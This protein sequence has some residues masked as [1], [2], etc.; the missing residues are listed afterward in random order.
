[1][2]SGYYSY[3]GG[4][5]AELPGIERFEGQV[6]HPQRWPDD[7]DYRGKRVVVIGSGATAMTLVPAMAPDVEHITMLQ[8]SPTYVVA[9]PDR[10]AIANR[11]RKLLPDSRRLPDHASQEH[12]PRPVLLRPHANATRQDARADARRRPQGARGRDDRA[13][14]TPSLQPV[15]SAPVPDPQRRPVRGDHVRQGLGRHRSHRDVQ[16]ERDRACVPGPSSR[17]TSSSPR[18]ACNW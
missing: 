5:A 1:M 8:R 15:G 18:P 4:Y 10:D 12:R 7:L 16:P 11:L 3:K 14:F 17:P 9:R 13:H 2:C 6:V